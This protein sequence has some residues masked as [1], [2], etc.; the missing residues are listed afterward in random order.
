M[1]TGMWPDRRLLERLDIAHPIIQAPMAGAST[2]ELV[3]AVSNAGGLGSLGAA[4]MQPDAIRA[5]IREIRRQTQRPFAVNLFTYPVPAPE[6]EKIS[7]MKQRIAGY[8]KALGGDPARLPAMPPLPDMAE[9]MAVIRDEAPPVF[10][11]TFGLPSRDDIAALR[12]KGAYTIGTATT[13]AE[14]K[15]LAELGVD[16]VVA[17]GSE[18]GGHRGTFAGPIEDSLIGTMALVPMMADAIALPVIAAGGIM[19]GR[20]IAAAFMLGAAGAALGT[21]FLACPE[22][23]VVSPVYRD[24]LLGGGLPTVVTRA[25]TGRHARFLKNR[26]VAEM[27]E[28]AAEIPSYP[29]QI[30]LTAPLRALGAEMKQPEIMPMLAGQAYPMIR[31]LPAGELVQTLVREAA[32]LFVGAK[33]G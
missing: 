6:A 11:F 19:D 3:A 13:V 29:H 32:D 5:A 30:P 1:E 8:V 4:M 22:N 9:Q 33:A 18:A 23:S 2:P 27:A 14:G 16:A 15:A 12:G 21:A 10:S 26:F 17:Q 31:A 7:R 24:T 28:A 25:Y 20:G